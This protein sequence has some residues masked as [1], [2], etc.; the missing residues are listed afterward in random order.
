MGVKGNMAEFSDYA[1]TYTT[2]SK[3]EFIRRVRD[4]PITF[5]PLVEGMNDPIW[6]CFCAY[7]NDGPVCT[8][9]GALRP[10]LSERVEAAIEKHMP[11]EDDW[12]AIQNAADGAI[13]ALDKTFGRDEPSESFDAESR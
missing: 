8:H 4:C 12:L 3:E 2:I 1:D 10:S 13:V 9:C 6:T 7:M 5:Q 11:S